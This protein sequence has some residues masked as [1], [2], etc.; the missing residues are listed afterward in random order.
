MLFKMN[1]IQAVIWDMDGVIVDS[2]DHHHK[3]EIE[4]FKHFGIDIPEEENK[5]YKGSPLREHFQGLK[6]QFKV[7]TSLDK[8]LEK[9]NEHIE[10]MYSKYVE[11]FENVEE[12]LKT[13][14]GNYL[15]ALATS[16][17]RRFVDIMIKR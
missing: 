5:K 6:E 12:V 4:T 16:T 11:L 9:Q 2:E 1:R 13:L 8:L 17:E 7:E 14:K 10:K 15:Q 3:G